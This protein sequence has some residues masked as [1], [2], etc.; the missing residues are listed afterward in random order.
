MAKLDIHQVLLI[1]VVQV[2]ILHTTTGFLYKDQVIRLGKKSAAARHYAPKN[3]FSFFDTDGNG[4]IS[5][6]EF[7]RIPQF[8]FST[9]S[10]SYKRA[11]LDG[12]GELND[13]EFF[14]KMAKIRY[15]AQRTV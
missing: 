11:D 7:Q 6:E 10:D 2:I 1:L 12:D 3:Q 9:L 13:F 15:A 8:R 5:L 14:S 4:R